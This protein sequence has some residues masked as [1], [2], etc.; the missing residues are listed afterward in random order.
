MAQQVK[1][2]TLSLWRCGFNP[3]PRSFGVATTYGV[4]CSCS[5]DLVFTWLWHMPATIAPN[6]LVAQELLYAAGVAVKYINIVC[7][8][9]NKGHNLH[10]Q[11]EK[12]ESQ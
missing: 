6:Q 7:S 1:D 10:F 8:P 5:S 9:M 3:W 12:N 4:G 2:P 11:D